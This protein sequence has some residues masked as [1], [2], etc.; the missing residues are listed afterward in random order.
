MGHKPKC[1]DNSVDV[2]PVDLEHFSSAIYVHIVGMQISAGIL[3]GEIFMNRYQKQIIWTLFKKQRK[4]HF[5]NFSGK[6]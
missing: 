6:L 1:E 2:V 3:L 4:N 5:G